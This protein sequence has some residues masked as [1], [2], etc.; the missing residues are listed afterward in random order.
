MA[1]VTETIHVAASADQVWG[2]IGDFHGLASWHPLIVNSEKLEEDGVVYRK[3][4]LGDGGV[5]IES[6]DHQDDERR[7]STYSMTD[8]GPMPLASYQATLAVKEADGNTAII[9]W[10]GTFEPKGAPV[11]DVAQAVSGIYTSGFG[12]VIERFGAAG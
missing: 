12:A 11:E 3:L 4:T 1:N 6:M 2:M 7:S 8:V 5:V 9:E 10:V